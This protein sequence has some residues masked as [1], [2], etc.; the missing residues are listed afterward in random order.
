[1]NENMWTGD[2]IEVDV[3]GFFTTHHRLQAASGELGTLTLPAFS[4]GGKFRFADGREIVAERTS[5]WRGWH[6][7]RV[8]SVVVA[9]ARPVGFWRQRMS[10]GYR[11]QAY[12]LVSISCWGRGW[13]LFEGDGG[14]SAV[15]EVQP[16][17][18][19][20]RGAYLQPFA[21]VPTD[22]LIFVYYLVN[23]RWQEQAS[24]AAATSSAAA[25]S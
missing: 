9:T 2:E 6:E 22:L 16:R 17:G 4:R 12:E 5:W 8:D 21:P 25:G 18:V 19:F 24:A 7:L 1:M 20:R 3:W 23:A 13:R 10:V 14:G 15:V 11:G